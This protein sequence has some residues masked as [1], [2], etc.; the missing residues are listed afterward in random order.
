MTTITEILVATDFGQAAAEALTYGRTLARSFGASLHV[1]HVVENVFLRAIV[2]DPSHVE[3]VARRQLI[4]GLT[5]DD[6]TTLHARIVIETSDQPAEAIVAYAR[7]A[8][9][10]LI[11]MGTHGRGTMERL[12]MG[13]VA[14]RVIRTAP[15]PVLTV[16]HPDVESSSRRPA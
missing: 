16:R 5:D 11:V 13:S 4:E 2:A 8:N 1:L 3:A 14:E 9:I 12:L 7:A 6:Q 10:S 15:C